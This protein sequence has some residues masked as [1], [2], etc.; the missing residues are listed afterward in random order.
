MG[1][2]AGAP[3]AAEARAGRRSGLRGRRRAAARRAAPGARS[4]RAMSAVRVRGRGLRAA[5][6]AG[7]GAHGGAPQKSGAGPAGRQLPAATAACP[8]RAEPKAARRG[9]AAQSAG[10]RQ[11]RHGGPWLF[12]S[13]ARKSGDHQTGTAPAH[14]RHSDPPEALSAN[15]SPA[16]PLRRQRGEV[17]AAAAPEHRAHLCDIA[18]CALAPLP[19]RRRGHHQVGRAPPTLAPAH[20]GRRP[21]RRYRRRRPCASPTARPAPAAQTDPGNS[22]EAPGARQD[23]PRR[24][25]GG[26]A[27]RRVNGHRRGAAPNPRVGT[28]R[29]RRH[30]GAYMGLSRP[31]LS[32]AP[33]RRGRRHAPPARLLCEIGAVHLPRPP[34]QQ[35]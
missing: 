14:A 12:Q 20:E 27:T 26:R 7:R 6:G 25:D 21:H 23:R 8:P 5:G 24:P 10:Q 3:G 11:Q 15:E 33:V 17:P 9:I 1:W 22:R 13:A 35:R 32:A 19:P 34:R 28:A 2:P 30:P 16:A 18:R 4:A 31:A 29:P